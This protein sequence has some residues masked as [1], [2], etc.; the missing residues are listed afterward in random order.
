MHGGNVWR[1]DPAQWLDFSANVRPEGA[2]DWVLDALRR[3]LDNISYYPQLD[4]TR[5]SSALAS[6]LGVDASL[7]LPTAGG[8]SAISLASYVPAEEAVVF[9]PSFS[10]YAEQA[11]LRGQRVSCVSLLRGREILPLRDCAAPYLR[12]G[13][14]LWLCNPSNP[15]GTVF[16]REDILALL[17]DVEAAHGYLIVDEAFIDFCPGFSVRDL[18]AEHERLAVTGSLTKSLGIPGV[19]LG[20]LCSQMSGRLREHQLPWE[21]NCFAE[22]VALALPGHAADIARDAEINAERRARF[23]S[24]LRGLGVYVYPSSANF[25]TVDLG[26]DAEA[27]ETALY[28]KNILVRG[29]DDFIGINDGRHLRIAVKDDDTNAAFIAA[30]KEALRCAENR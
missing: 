14:C 8:A 3:G 17:S 10:E 18:T 21:L 15:L 24:A 19:R 5:A 30:L 1:G 4:M 22:A 25:L 28:K 12:R 27:V 26:A 9:T 16:S 29:C 6:Y 7:V 13:V 11:A 20:Y 2:P 23:A